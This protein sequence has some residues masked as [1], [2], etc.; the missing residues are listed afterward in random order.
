MA[1]YGLAVT[2][3]EAKAGREK[4]AI[5]LFGEAVAFNEKL[6]A[7]GGMERWDVVGFEPIGSAPAGVMRYYGTAAQ[8]EALVTSEEFSRLI[9][10]GQLTLD[11]FGFRRFVTGQALMEEVGRYS[12]AI[13]AL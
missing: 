2:W 11:S 8:T 7:N 12:S 9:G 1:D 6:V 5:E 10:R 13:D 4:K 3:G